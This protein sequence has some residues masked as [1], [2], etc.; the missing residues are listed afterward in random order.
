MNLEQC[1]KVF[2]MARKFRL[3]IEYLMQLE[4]QGKAFTIDYFTIALESNAFDVAFYLFAR[5]EDEINLEHQRSISALVQSYWGS[6]KMLKAKLH[7]TKTLLPIFSFNG[8]KSYLQMLQTKIHDSSLESNLFSHA[9]NPLLCMCLLYEFLQLLALKFFSLSNMCRALSERIKQM[10]TLYIDA[11][12]DE[13]FL[14][15]LMSEKDYSG[16][17]LLKIAVQ[18]ELLD[19]I[20]SPKVEAIIQRI[21]NSDYETAGS[22]MQMSTTS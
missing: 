1:I 14:T 5:Y 18:L 2:I 11:V 12:D 20:Q 22:L 4:E 10:A 9:S 8:A 17:D 7:M 3:S 15:S 6:N 19:L 13:H 16:R 21:W